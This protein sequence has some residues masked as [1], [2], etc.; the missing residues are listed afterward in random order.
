MEF[1]TST[2]LAKIVVGIPFLPNT[3]ESAKPK[4]PAPI[5]A[6]RTGYGGVPREDTYKPV[7]VVGAVPEAVMK[8][9]LLVKA[10]LGINKAK[11]TIVRLNN[12]GEKMIHRR[13]NLFEALWHRNVIFK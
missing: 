10:L 3:D 8:P 1:A 9:P 13:M 7:L 5:I 6:T 12:A 4:L 11:Q 2:L